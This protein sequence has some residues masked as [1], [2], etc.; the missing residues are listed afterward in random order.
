VDED[1]DNLD[2]WIAELRD[3]LAR[4]ELDGG[5]PI[6]IGGLRLPSAQ[7]AARIM[8]AD[9]DHYDD[10]SPEERGD[11]LVEAR[12]GML[13]RDFRRLRALIG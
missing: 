9:L 11:W 5:A 13:L 6:E 3:R 8:V 4:G 7:L 2:A 10:L 12:R 1:R